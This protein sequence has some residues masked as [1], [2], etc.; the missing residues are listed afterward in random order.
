[1]LNRVVLVLVL[2]GWAASNALAADV[3]FSR[4]VRPILSNKCYACHG[5]DE[6]QRQGGD[7]SEGGLRFDTEQ[8]AMIDLGGYFAIVPGKP[9]ESELIRRIH[10]DD[11][12]E[13]MPPPDHPAQLSAEERATLTAWIEQGAQWDQHW[14]FLPPKKHPAPQTRDEQWPQNLIDYFV[15]ERLEGAGLAPSPPAESHTLLRR[16]SF[17]LVGLPPAYEDVRS[18]MADGA[19]T[20]YES[21]VDRLLNSP[22]YG[23]RMA[24][25][26]LD[27]VR[28]ADSVG[29]HGDQP[30]SVSPFRDY[31]IDAF[32]DN[33]P[34]D[35]FTLEQL[36]GDL[37]T[38]PSRDQ[39]IAS[40]YNRLGMMSAEGGVQPE[41]YLAKYASDRVRTASGVWLG[42]TLGCAECH[43]HKFDPFTTR[44]FYRFAAFFADIKERGLYSGANDSGRWGP[45]IDV[46]D[47]RLPELLAPIQQELAELSEILDTPSEELGR[48]QLEWER[49]VANAPKW[50]V[51]LPSTAEA[52]HGTELKIRSNGSLLAGG[53]NPEQNVYTVVAKA[54]LDDVTGFRI[55]VRPDKSL[56][57][58]GPGRAGNGN[59]VVTEIR[60]FSQPDDGSEP[61]AVPL[62]NASAT[63]EQASD[64]ETPAETWSAAYTIDADVESSD[65]GW[66]ILPATGQLNSMVLETAE[67]TPGTRFTFVIEQNH[68]NP[69]HTLGCFRIFA[70]S[71]PRPL[72]ADNQPRPPASI[73]TILALAAEERDAD[74]AAE[75]AAY[76]R[77]IAP[78]LADVRARVEE[79]ESQ[80]AQLIKDNTR[81]T[82]VTAAVEP[83]T[84]RVL[85]RGNWMDQSGEVVLPGTPS[86]LR[87]FDG[88]DR[89]DRRDLARWL[90]STDNPLTARV[91]VNR[92][93]YL[94]FGAGLSK[95]LDDVGAQGEVPS[96]PELLD[97][98]A[99]EFMESGWDVKHMIKL[100]V[101]SATYRQSSMRAELQDVDPY[102]R[103][104]A[105]QS[106]FRIDAEMIRDNALAVSG[107][108]V[109]DIGGESVKPYQPPG[110]YRHLN[111]PTR[112]YEPDT[113]EKQYRR[114]VYT[115]WQRQFLHPAMKSFDAPSREECTA[116]RPRSNTP[117]GAL[118]LLNDPSYV[119]AAHVFA[120]NV[121][122]HG[123]DETESRLAWMMQRALSRHPTEHE[124]AVL[125]E[126][127]SSQYEHYA[128]HQQDAQALVDTGSTPVS[129][130]VDVVEL[131]AWTAVARVIFNMHEFIT[132]N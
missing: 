84:M 98:L 101:M 110:L 69:Q 128:Q 118:V 111:F 32:N 25:Y 113:G 51:L 75:L 33:L 107:L 56:P 41:E 82:L 127:L 129:E 59:F 38:E 9:G 83:R 17:D 54:D 77:S 19:V 5:P 4:D 109:A 8:A 36:A 91:F 123:G 37:L 106:R 67:A 100:I 125:T 53:P 114:G 26:W 105:R 43:D 126:L 92:L 12:D 86:F 35:R 45:Q 60:V 27:L 11:P 89:A 21:V 22:H 6:E 74:Q 70:T 3:D 90:T 112:T 122:E 73:R 85:H 96:H 61:V 131:A 28:Y 102:N 50:K 13:A 48:A 88:E 20:A 116:R 14:A 16:L 79:L 65:W 119:E 29:Y 2:T 57:E 97:T 55:E 10:A 72:K 87:Q 34:F 66:A 7:P 23:E 103:L 124:I 81:T 93:W 47:E 132:R 24:M 94:F 30:V 46:P 44:D 18:F 71:S 115:H 1:M 58:K 31:V 42:A 15:L 120:A 39:L 40:G 108:L 117:L 99:V 52:M 49:H 76:Y 64:G 121:I 78:A 104:L 130:D 62:Q 95:V 63:I 68:S 80:Q